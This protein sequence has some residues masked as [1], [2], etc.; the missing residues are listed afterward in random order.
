MIGDNF[1]SYRILKDKIIK[2]R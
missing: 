1:I 2:N